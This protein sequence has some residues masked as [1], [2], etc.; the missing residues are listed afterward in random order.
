MFFLSMLT[1]AGIGVDTFCM[2]FFMGGFK[3]PCGLFE[4]FLLKE[5]LLPIAGCFRRCGN[6]LVLTLLEF[7]HIC[8]FLSTIPL[9]TFLPNSHADEIGQKTGSW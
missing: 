9:C 4:T 2:K 1:F 8:D 3:G 7:S 5:F 6:S